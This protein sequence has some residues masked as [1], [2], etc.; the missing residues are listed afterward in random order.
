MD[1]TYIKD[2]N[3]HIGKEVTVKG[4]VDVRRDQGKMVFLDLR[5]MSGRV[6]AVVLPNHVE[7]LDVAQRL[8]PEWV[9]RVSAI[10]NKRP[11]RN[12][13]ADILNGDIELEVLNIEVLNE[14]QTPPMDVTSDGHEI[15]EEV[16]LKYRYLDLRRPRLQRNL[17]LRHDI[18][19]Q[20]RNFLSNSGFI[21]IETPLL[22]KSTP[23]GSRD[24]VVP[25]RIEQGKFYALPQSP[26]QYKQLLMVAGMEKYFQIARCMRDE[27]TRG[28]RQPEF[29]QLDM[30]LSFATK[31]EIMELNEKLLIELVQT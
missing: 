2:L 10:V 30:E 25:S 15:G 4:W 18:T 17:R 23:E 9:V 22:T 7:A 28:D 11:E 8:R 27:D 20:V 29:T 26:Q 24:Y 13:K 21:E 19:L 3:K 1:R 16:R 6:Q 12:I 5:D 14:S 31:E